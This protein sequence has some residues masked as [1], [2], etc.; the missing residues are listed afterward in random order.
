[1]SFPTTPAFVHA[2][3]W[4]DETRKHPAMKWMENFTRTFNK[5]EEWDKEESEWLSQDFT[6]VK[7]DGKSSTGNAVAFAESK[8][9][10][11][12]FTSEFHE[13]YFI[14][15][16]ETKDG[17]EM[18]GQAHIFANL[19]GNATAQEKKVQ[20]LSGRDWD[21]KIPGAFHFWYVK[22]DGAP[23]GGILMK[24]KEVMSDSLPVVQILTT[25]GVLQ[26]P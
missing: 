13:P 11:Q 20:D 26:Q 24:K 15:T 12:H 3:T 2:G 5:R 19:R 9:M 6:F 18:I 22:Q 14:I 23:H 21:I 8:N 7:P 1:M 25:R 10:Y 17:W 16:W 4:D